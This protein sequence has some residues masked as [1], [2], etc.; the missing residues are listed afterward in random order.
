MSDRDLVPVKTNGS[1][2]KLPAPKQHNFIASFQAL[3]ELL[4]EQVK[5]FEFLYYE[6]RDNRNQRVDFQHEG[7][8]A[9]YWQSLWTQLRDD[10]VKC[11]ADLNQLWATKTDFMDDYHHPTK[12]YLIY[13]IGQMLMA[14]PDANAS[15]EY[16]ERMAE[17]LEAEDCNAMLWESVF[18]EIEDKQKK[19]P[20]ISE[21]LSLSER[22][23]AKW[24]QRLDAIDL[25]KIQQ[26]GET[27][28]S[29][30]E[31]KNAV[32]KD[33]VL[34][35]LDAHSYAEWAADVRDGELYPYYAALQAFAKTEGLSELVAKM[36][37]DSLY[38]YDEAARYLAGFKH[39]ALEW[40]LLLKNA[41]RR[42]NKDK[43][44][45]CATCGFGYEALSNRCAVCAS[46]GRVVSHAKW[47]ANIAR[48]QDDLRAKLE[49]E[50]WLKTYLES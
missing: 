33:A 35:Y 45:A 3:T 38:D 21:V 48:E 27:L 40:D 18:R 28:V 47:D 43:A 37:N 25:D 36:E 16:A 26:M 17:R 15:V 13:R 20:S 23:Q 6:W 49:E 50:A 2:G 8:T 4:D 1:K 39:I 9:D 32:F 5:D 31:F 46:V 7:E 24:R 19:P 29:A 34:E 41:Q 11:L 42:V 12:S 22:H 14:W 30:L 44:F 10:A